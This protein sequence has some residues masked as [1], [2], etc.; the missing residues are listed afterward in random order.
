MTDTS[1]VSA[2]SH[3]MLGVKVECSLQVMGVPVRF[4]PIDGECP[5][6]KTNSAFTTLILAKQGNK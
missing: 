5:K 4:R 6:P 3:C 1:R 2:G